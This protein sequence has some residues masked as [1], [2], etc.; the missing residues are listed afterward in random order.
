MNQVSGRF[1]TILG[2][3]RN[4]A[5]G[6][7]SIAAGYSANAYGDYSVT[8][9]LTGE[10]CTNDLA[11]SFAICSNTLSLNGDDVAKTLEYM[12]SRRGLTESKEM[13]ADVEGKLGEHSKLIEEHHKHNDAQDELMAQQEKTISE[14]QALLSAVQGLSA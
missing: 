3:G 2:G 4:Y 5:R 11:H 14:I 1:G 8:F 9:G 12:E 6:R 7:Y 10:E 13:V